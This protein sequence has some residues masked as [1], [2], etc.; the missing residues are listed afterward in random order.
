MCQASSSVVRRELGLAQLSVGND[1]HRGRGA[2]VMGIFRIPQLNG[3][4]LSDQ[5]PEK[6]ILTAELPPK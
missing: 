1:S 3:Y 6:K 2:T 4:K 5:R